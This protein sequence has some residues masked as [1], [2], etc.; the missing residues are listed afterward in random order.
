MA[1]V[2]HHHTP[3]NHLDQAIKS[4]VQH[5][6][7]I[8]LIALLGMFIYQVKVVYPTMDKNL[9]NSQSLESD[10]HRTSLHHR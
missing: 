8:V 2:R 4:V 6:W 10:Q 7:T 5:I 3:D 9:M 1:K